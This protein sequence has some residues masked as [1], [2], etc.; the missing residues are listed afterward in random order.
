[1]ST[2]A[3]GRILRFGPFEVDVRTGEL[4]KHG[5]KIRL[6]EQPFEILIM[7]LERPGALITREEVRQ[8]L[9][10]AD[11]FV[12]FDHGLNNAVNR[13]REALGDSAET[14]RFIETLPRKGY[15]FLASVNRE[16][17]TESVISVGAL[18]KELEVNPPSWP[19][20]AT[21]AGSSVPRK[22]MLRWGTLLVAVGTPAIFLM[23]WLRPANLPRVIGSTQI[24]SDGR[25]KT[26]LV[27]DGSRLYFSEVAAGHPILSQ[28]S[29]TGG[30]TA[31]IAVPF[32]TF[33]LGDFSPSRGELLLSGSLGGSDLETPLWT[34]RLP[35]GT[36]RRVGDIVTNGAAW[37]HNSEK[38]TYTHG[39]D[40]YVSKSDGSQPRKLASV[41]N[42]PLWARWSPKEDVVR[43]T[44]YDFETNSTS[45]WE[46]ASDGSRLHPLLPGTNAKEDCCGN[47][48]RG[49]EYYLFHSEGN[50]WAL[51]EQAEFLR[52]PTKNPV[53]LT[54]GPL[55]LTYPVP[56]TDGKKVFVIGQQ[57]RAEVVRYDSKAKEFVPYIAG[58][59]AGQL[60]FS[61]D[62]KWVAY[63]AYP[64]ATLWRCKVDGSGRQQLTYSPLRA[65][66]PHW[67]PDGERIA[68]M[69]SEPGRHWRIFLISV[70]DGSVQDLLPTQ[71]N[72]IGDPNWSPDGNSLAFGSLATGASSQM[73]IRLLNLRNKQISTVPGSEGMFSPR[74]S[75]NGR[76]LAA[77]PADSQKLMLF[78]FTAQKWFA[79]VNRAIGYPSWSKDSKY[80]F[81][82][83]TSFNIDPAIYRLNISDRSLQRVVS[84]KDIRQYV[85]DWPFGA[86]TGLTPDDSPL[87]QRDISTQEIYALDLQLP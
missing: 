9:W 26:D 7:L 85:A 29:A 63:V 56:S 21:P 67:S 73:T 30:E 80:I 24:T 40:I 28:V 83:D 25:L 45:L 60:D 27:T 53:Q 3:S 38:I 37:S 8:K 61:R 13:L 81:F 34:L 78:D 50:I 74:W 4:R 20:T 2:F 32:T 10:P 19:A 69:A 75:P 18:G 41:G 65:A 6:Q 47:W 14:P 71:N 62:G 72:N 11:T 76:F 1:M 31:Q 70:T 58:V 51:R 36:P 22:R 43:F 44:E 68:F 46:V 64:E 12:D 49:G 79:L 57:R 42:Y 77:L 54:F 86:W 5:L 33:R 84:L 15:R 16:A 66:L 23:F 17:N 52:K 59:S 39:H 82:D 35:A 48:T 55:Q 87:L